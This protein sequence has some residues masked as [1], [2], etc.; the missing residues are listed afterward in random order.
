MSQFKDN[1]LIESIIV[2]LP[3]SLA[4]KFDNPILKDK[5]WSMDWDNTAKEI[6][7]DLNIA[8]EDEIISKSE[9][10]Y[11]HNM[12]FHSFGKIGSS[13]SS[14]FFRFYTGI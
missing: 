2:K 7:M 4:E 12:V 11:I 5:K 10:N 8:R 1:E 3:V 13:S 6:V 14:D 9:Y